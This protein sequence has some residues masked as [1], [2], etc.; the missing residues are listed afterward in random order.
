[1]GDM[2]IE[3]FLN[4]NYFDESIYD[5]AETYRELYNIISESIENYS[6]VEISNYD[7]KLKLAAIRIKAQYPID[8]RP[9][10]DDTL[11]IMQWL[12]DADRLVSK[13]EKQGTKTSKPEVPLRC[14]RANQSYED[15]LEKGNQLGKRW[16]GD[17]R[18]IY[19]YARANLDFDYEFPQRFSTWQR[20]RREYAKIIDKQKRYADEI[21]TKTDT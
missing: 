17:D 7:D 1:M 16:I 4:S 8:I 14:L 2:E 10:P 6:L 12:L 21:R 15:A 18:E 5:C 9:L 11:D 3:F 20:Y 19:N 13:P